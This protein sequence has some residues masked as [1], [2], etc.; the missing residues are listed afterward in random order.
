MNRSEKTRQ[1]SGAHPDVLADMALA[2]RRP[3]TMLSVKRTLAITGALV[4]L[5][6]LAPIASAGTAQ[7]FYLDKTCTDDANEPLGFFCTVENSNFKW[8]P[9]GTDIR[10]AEIPGFD[11]YEVQAATITIPNGSTTGVC[12]W[13]YPDGPVVATC[14]FGPGTGRLAQFHLVVDVTV[15]E[16]WVWY[17]NGTY[18][19]GN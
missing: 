8:I 10:Y 11:P 19:F 16:S 12:D 17:W 5:A 9:A 2:Q 18:W 6:A 13:R 4:A 3:S 15:D 1:E 7:D 14:T